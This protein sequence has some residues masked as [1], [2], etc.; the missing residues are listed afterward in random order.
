MKHTKPFFTALKERSPSPL[1]RPLSDLLEHREVQ[2]VPEW[3]IQQEAAPSP[4]T[5]GVDDSPPPAPLDPEMLQRLGAGIE[6]LRKAHRALADAP[7]VVALAMTVAQAI[8]ERELSI[9]PAALSSAIETALGALRDETSIKLRVAPGLHEW[10]EEA[11]PSLLD[12]GLE[13]E[14]ISDPTLEVG[15]CIVEGEQHVLDVSLSGR[16]KRFENAMREVLERAD[17]E[18]TP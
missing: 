14:I 2:R 12:D 3:L 11:R 4:L 15:G 9:D 5:S 1:P 13:I 10:L 7:D 16:L 18:S 8:L 17:E 6:S